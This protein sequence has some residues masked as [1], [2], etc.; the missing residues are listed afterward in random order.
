MRAAWEVTVE[1]MKA[2][3]QH[4]VLYQMH[5]PRVLHSLPFLMFSAVLAAASLKVLLFT[6][7]SS[8]SR[9]LFS[10]RQGRGVGTGEDK[11]TNIVL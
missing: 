4:A 9:C 11:A 1:H 5:M 10:C 6:N 7:F 8:A 3:Q 2:E